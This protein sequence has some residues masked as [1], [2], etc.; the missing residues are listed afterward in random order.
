MT[1]MRL[2][3]PTRLE[4]CL[5]TAVQGVFFTLFGLFYAASPRTAHR[6][7]GYLEEE[8]IVSYTR[9]LEE[10]DAGRIENIAAP[11]IAIEY[12]NLS[13]SARLRDVVLAVRADEAAHR[14]V[15]HHFA[16][17]ILVGQEDL[18]KSFPAP[19]AAK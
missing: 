2:T 8:A 11:D 15:N 4:R 10:I 14:D 5:I 7:V 16:D 3:K 1:W 9:F 17:R 6:M 18:R 12:W 19:D 13:P